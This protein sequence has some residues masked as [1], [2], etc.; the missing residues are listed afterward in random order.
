MQQKEQKCMK[1]RDKQFWAY[2][3]LNIKWSE[4]L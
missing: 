1:K 4:D 2:G 3:F